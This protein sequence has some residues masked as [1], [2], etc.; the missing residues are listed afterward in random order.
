MRASPRASTTRRTP[1][2]TPTCASTACFM[3]RTWSGSGEQRS[4]AAAPSSTWSAGGGRS[5]RPGADAR[6]TQ[7]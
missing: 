1:A 6:E 4:T 2:A 7:G 5:V 3:T